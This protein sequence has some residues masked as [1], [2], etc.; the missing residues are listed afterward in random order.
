MARSLLGFTERSTLP[1]IS[2]LKMATI[3]PCDKESH[4]SVFLLL[5][6]GLRRINSCERMY[7]IGPFRT[8]LGL[9]LQAVTGR[10]A[11]LLP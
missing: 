6:A 10:K 2:C 5:R 1:F 8:R 9:D 7:D 3:K 11:T 4:F